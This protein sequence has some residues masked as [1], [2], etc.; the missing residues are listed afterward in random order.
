MTQDISPLEEILVVEEAREA[1]KTGYDLHIRSHGKHAAEACFSSFDKR[2]SS[3][4]FI[5]SRSTNPYYGNFSV[6][7]NEVTE[8]IKYVLANCSDWNVLIDPELRYFAE[9][10]IS[11]ERNALELSTAMTADIPNMFVEPYKPT[12]IQKAAIAFHEYGDYNKI[13][14]LVTGAGKT[15]VGIGYA[16]RGYNK[17]LKQKG[18]RTIWMCKAGA[19]AKRIAEIKKFTGKV[20]VEL[21]GRVPDH[22]TLVALQSP[23]VQYFVLP[24]EVVGTEYFE[25][26]QAKDIGDAIK[27]SYESPSIP[28]ANMLNLL[29][30]A[31]YIDLIVADEAHNFRNME[32]KAAKFMLALTIPRRLPMTATPFVNTGHDIY[33]LLRFCDPK[34]FPSEQG[35]ID[36]YYTQDGKSVRNEQGLHKM[37]SMYL[38]RRSFK[39]VFGDVDLE[40]DNMRVD[41]LTHLVEI[42]SGSTHD[43]RLKALEDNMYLDLA[44]NTDDAKVLSHILPKL[45]AYRQIVED[46]KTQATIDLAKDMLAQGKKLLVFFNFQANVEQAAKS[47]GCKYIHGEV[48]MNVRTVYEKEFQEDATVRC[49]AVSMKTMQE[50][51]TMTAGTDIIICGYPWTAKDIV[52]AEGRCFLRTNDPHGGT[53]TF[54]KTNTMIDEFLSQI[55]TRKLKAATTSVDGTRD[56]ADLNVSVVKEL[57]G[58]LR[59]FKTR[60]FTT[61]Y[62]GA[63]N[64]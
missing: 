13:N 50:D 42:E 18:Y 7:I 8:L 22:A 53:A 35:F 64:R 58:M 49:L 55:Y 33:T 2:F 43:E 40:S 63:S 39:D 48:P 34:T 16:E 17:L 37:F 15:A 20:A 45:N 19:V 41:R 6:P 51:K 25:D 26:K 14:S 4:R 30:Q 23:D 44:L 61:T 12:D 59:G 11:R 38:F 24:Y 1:K 32:T 5:G 9:R 36:S 3:G 29:S 52:Q 27:K 31:G 21:G 46:A 28:W 60:S 62:Q 56:F 10:E 54:M 47:L 57:L